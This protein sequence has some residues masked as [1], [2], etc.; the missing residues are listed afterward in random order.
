MHINTAII[1]AFVLIGA[2]PLSAQDAAPAA[3][4]TGTDY[5][6]ARFDPCR[7][8]VLCPDP[9]TLDTEQVPLA[10]NFRAPDELPKPKP[11]IK[12]QRTRALVFFRNG[13]FVQVVHYARSHIARAGGHTF[14]AAPGDAP[15]MAQIER[16]LF[17]KAAVA[18]ALTW[19]DRQFCGGSLIASGWIV[20]AAHC[21]H[22]YGK[23]IK[24]GGYRVRLGLSDIKLGIKGVSYAIDRIVEHPD[25]PKSPDFYNDIGLIHFAADDQ[26][27]LD[28]DGSRRRIAAIAIDSGTSGKNEV[29]GREAWFFGWGTTDS[30]HPSAP[31]QYGK[32][33]LSPDNRCSN[34]GIAL[35]GRGVG[36]HGATQCHGDSGGPLVFDN[37]HAPFLI[38]LV[39]HN[40]G[41]QTCGVNEKQGV[42]TRVAAYR[43]WIEGYTGPLRSPPRVVEPRPAAE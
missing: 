12:K 17:V 25:F 36:A 41:K 3:A 32:I 18:R 16:P 13:R 42:Y 6:P 31:L 9:L 27:R 10:S 7:R 37:D 24:T 29:G 19:E 2:G 15:W 26:T 5:V 11:K 40:T 28:S 38:G 21:L 35:C 20:T 1:A 33:K 14:T 8:A 23:D 30:Q 4:A 22:D 43:S 39:S 34:S